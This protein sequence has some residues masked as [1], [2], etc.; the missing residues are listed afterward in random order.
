MSNN[1]SNNH[2]LT[3]AEVIIIE[4]KESNKN[5][6]LSLMNSNCSCSL[7]ACLPGDVD[8]GRCSSK[9]FC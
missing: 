4:I 6:S 2:A 7:W 3:Q 8:L 1:E 5:T 9:P